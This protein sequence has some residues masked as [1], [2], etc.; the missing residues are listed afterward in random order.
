M[1]GTF[2]QEKLVSS[3]KN[4]VG[5]TLKGSLYKRE[6]PNDAA[7]IYDTWDVANSTDSSQLIESLEGAVSSDVDICSE[8]GVELMQK[9]G[10][11][12]DAIIGRPCYFESAFFCSLLTS[13]IGTAACIGTVNMFA[14]GIG[15]GGFA[16]VRTASGESRSFNFREMAPKA[17][18]KDMYH[19]ILSLL[20]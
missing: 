6:I 11:A 14:S 20:T 2:L 12:V 18:Y 1:G 7:W 8:I 19:G 9:G 17:A 15:G 5:P 16:V 4:A 3:R 13:T 10:N